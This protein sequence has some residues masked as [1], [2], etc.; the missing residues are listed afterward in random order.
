MLATI[1][2]VCSHWRVELANRLEVLG[3]SSEVDRF[4]VHIR[5][6]VLTTAKGVGADPTRLKNRSRF[7]HVMDQL[8]TGTPNLYRSQ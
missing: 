5:R 2:K 1:F 6:L 7:G 8:A 3:S 4:R